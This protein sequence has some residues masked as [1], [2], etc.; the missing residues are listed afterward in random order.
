MPTSTTPPIVSGPSP[1]PVVPPLRLPSMVSSHQ[2]GG[3][4]HPP[5]RPPPPPAPRSSRSRVLTALLLL[6]ALVGALAVSARAF[7]PTGSQGDDALTPRAAW[8]G[9]GAA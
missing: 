2:G 5:P 9:G 1:R 3:A 7:P 8:V 4:F 6:A